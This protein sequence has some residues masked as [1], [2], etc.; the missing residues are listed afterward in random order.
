MEISFPFSYFSGYP[1]ATIITVLAV[2][3]SISTSL[4]ESVSVAIPS[5]SSSMSDLRRGK[6]T[7]VSGSPSLQL[8]S[9]T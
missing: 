2:L 7:S 4:S 8:Y 9:M 1:P 3:K 6:T 5:K